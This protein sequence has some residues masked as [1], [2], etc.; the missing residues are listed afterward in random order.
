MSK[1]KEQEVASSKDTTEEIKLRQGTDGVYE[2]ASIEEVKKAR[3][4]LTQ[5]L[6]GKKKKPVTSDNEE[7]FVDGF[8]K[9]FAVV[10][11][12]GEALKVKI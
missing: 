6:V 9:G 1:S 12:I 2:A 3:K 10:R 4:P 7:Q 8:R 11:K 5:K